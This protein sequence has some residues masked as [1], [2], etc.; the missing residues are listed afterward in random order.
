MY[1]W[2]YR[3]RLPKAQVITAQV[4]ILDYI[5]LWIHIVFNHLH[6]LFEI[7]LNTTIDWK[8]GQSRDFFLYTAIYS[9]ELHTGNAFTT[10]TSLTLSFVPLKSS[11]SSFLPIGPVCFILHGHFAC[12]IVTSWRNIPLWRHKTS[13]GHPIHQIFCREKKEKG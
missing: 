11:A 1:L 12:K 2:I 7:D 8:I 10:L 3:I 13:Q 6:G 9:T 5:L 4:V